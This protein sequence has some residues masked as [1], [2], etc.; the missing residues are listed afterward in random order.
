[1]HNNLSQIPKVVE[2]WVTPGYV[3]LFWTLELLLAAALFI[4]GIIQWLLLP[5]IAGIV[6][7]ITGISSLKIVNQWEK[8]VVLRLGRLH[9]VMEPGPFIL[10]LGIETVAARIDQ[11]TQ[12]TTFTAEETLTK[13]TVPVNV[14]AV[15][16]WVVWDAQK[17]AFEVS[18]YQEAVSWAAQTALREILGS[19]PLAEVLAERENIDEILRKRIDRRTEPWGIAVYSVEIRDVIIPEELQ[20]AMS[21]EAQAE[22]ERKARIVLSQAEH[23]VAQQFVNAS[24]VYKDNPGALELRTINLLA[25]SIK[26][27]GGLIVVPSDIANLFNTGLTSSFWE[28][29]SIKNSE[30]TNKGVDSGL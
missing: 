30:K 12:I 25:E 5:I 10:L 15:L 2:G 11:R 16:F 13:D 4:M 7:L 9:R 22:R 14:D 19:S 27:K 8:V 3:W 18:N 23:E 26:S 6:L 1:M 17:A 21:R 29:N 20:V 28:N 24:N